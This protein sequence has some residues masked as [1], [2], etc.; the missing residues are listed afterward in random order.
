MEIDAAEAEGV[1]I[2]DRRRA[3]TICDG[4]VELV[5]VEPRIPGELAPDNFEPVAGEEASIE[6][7]LVVSAIGQRTD[8]TILADDDPELEW[9]E[10]GH[11]RVDR[12]TL[13]TSDPRVFAGGDLI[14]GQQTVTHAVASGL[15]AAW[16]IDA[17]LKGTSTADRRRPPPHVVTE[18]LSVRPGVERVDRGP[19]LEGPKLDPSTRVGGFR[20]VVGVLTEEQARAEAARCM[21][22]GQCANCRSCLD[23]FGCPAFRL[24]EGRIV[25]S[26]ELCIGCGVCALL[27]PNQA[28]TAAPGEGLFEPV[29]FAS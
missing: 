2:L 22:C 27:C 14:E 5:R 9:T 13:R 18:Q 24:E 21:F 3:D 1:E 19:R 7:G 17:A 6:A 26:P 8:P 20:E 4:M 16:G 12:D 28:I 10:G 15:R 29:S 11:L 25:V 23:L